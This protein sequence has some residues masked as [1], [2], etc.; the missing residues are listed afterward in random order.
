MP[1][2][3]DCLY[4]EAV[5]VLSQPSENYFLPENEIIKCLFNFDKVCLI[6]RGISSNCDYI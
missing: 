2:L 5:L 4:L 6:N 1:V 3:H